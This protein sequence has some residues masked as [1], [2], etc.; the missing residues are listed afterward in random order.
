MSILLIVIG[1]AGLVLGGDLLVRGAVAFAQRVGVSPLV[2][3]LTLVGFGTS[4][5]ELLTSVQAALAGAPGI[6]LGNVVGSNI[7][8]ILLILGVSAAMSPILIERGA[9]ARDGSALALVT[10]L[11]VGVTLWG[12]I[13]R[14]TGAIFIGLLAA[15]V[16][17]ALRAPGPDVP[18]VDGDALSMRRALIHAV[19]GLVLTLIGA[20]LLVDGAIDLADALGVSEAVIGLTVVAVGTSLPELVTSVAAARRGR[21]D[22]AFGNIIGSN[23]FNVVGILG[24]T[25]VVTP[26]PVAPQIAL[27]DIWIMLGATAIL[28]ALACWR[29]R[30]ARGAGVGFLML[31]GGYIGALAIMA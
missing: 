8:N 3:G 27:F 9:F 12:E 10:V 29:G 18:D 4:V 28:I 23:I 24:V 16:V 5:P 26:L 21:N 13:G 14:M 31:Y 1:F 20:K 15:Y 17:L 2:I 22:L 7:C 6:A 25:A 30:I 19:G 11:A